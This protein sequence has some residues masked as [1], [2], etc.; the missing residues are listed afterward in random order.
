MDHLGFII[1]NK[2]S[3]KINI[4]KNAILQK[5]LVFKE[6]FKNYCLIEP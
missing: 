6:Y 4:F 5:S 2:I 1:I 3:Y